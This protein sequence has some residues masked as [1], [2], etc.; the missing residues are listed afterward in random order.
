MF[1]KLLRPNLPGARADHQSK[2]KL[3]KQIQP[4]VPKAEHI[5]S[6]KVK[7]TVYRAFVRPILW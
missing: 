2:K 3:T 1:A 4:Y 5:Y 6:N 7:K